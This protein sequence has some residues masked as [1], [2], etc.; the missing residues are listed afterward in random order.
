LVS[1]SIGIA[2]FEEEVSTFDVSEFAQSVQDSVSGPLA[3]PSISSPGERKATETYHPS[4]LRFG[5]DWLYPGTGQ[6]GYQE[7]ATVHYSIT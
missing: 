6:R 3:R 4:C 2:S 1:D 7:A 5:V